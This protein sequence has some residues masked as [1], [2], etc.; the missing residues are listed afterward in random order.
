MILQM[1]ARA[2]GYVKLPLLHPTGLLTAPNVIPESEKFSFLISAANAKN[3][4]QRK[5][6]TIRFIKSLPPIVALVFGLSLPAVAADLGKLLKS[7]PERSEQ[8]R[9]NLFDLEPCMIE[10]DATQLPTVYQSLT[11]PKQFL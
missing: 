10:V 11:V 3:Q 8:T 7:E 4:L 1:D 9:H 6:M 5:A 2:K